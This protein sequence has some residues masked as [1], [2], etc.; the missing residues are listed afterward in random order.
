MWVTNTSGSY[1][2]NLEDNGPNNT[3]TLWHFAVTKAGPSTA[4]S[5]EAVIESPAQKYANFHSMTFYYLGG[6]C[7]P[8]C[9]LF[10]LG[11]GQ[12]PIQSSDAG[13]GTT[14]EATASGIDYS[15][16]TSPDFIMTYVQE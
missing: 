15:M 1:S 14:T 13:Y 7:S 9:Q 5:A 10:Q 16:F 4:A 6:A 8:A 12:P 3:S 2:L 11:T